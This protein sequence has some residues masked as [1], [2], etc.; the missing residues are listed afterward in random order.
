MKTYVV[1]GTLLI[2]L[3]SPALADYYVA[4]DLTTGACLIMRL[5]CQN[6]A[7]AGKLLAE[8]Y[9]KA[10]IKWRPGGNK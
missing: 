8:N 4:L 1:A 2:A 9:R 7:E 5:L 10:G 6:Q 3:A